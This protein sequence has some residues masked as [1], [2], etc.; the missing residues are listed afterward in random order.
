M[1]AEAIDELYQEIRGLKDVQQ[2]MPHL[3]EFLHFTVTLLGDTNATI[4]QT[5][6]KALSYLVDKLGARLSMHVSVVAKA[7]VER[8]GDVKKCGFT[9]AL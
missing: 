4:R 2:L 6:I 1:R 5:T 8:L 7:M 9:D 3:Q